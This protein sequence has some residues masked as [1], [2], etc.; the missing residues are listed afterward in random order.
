MDSSLVARKGQAAPDESGRS[1]DDPGERSASVSCVLQP[2]NRRAGAGVSETLTA[3]E[4]HTV[5]TIERHDTASPQSIALGDRRLRS[6]WLAA[7]SLQGQET[8]YQEM[9]ATGNVRRVAA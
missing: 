3:S 8:L 1:D 7:G 5:V 6:A 2:G 9:A 4:G